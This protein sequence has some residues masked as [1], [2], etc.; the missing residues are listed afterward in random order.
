M[1]AAQHHRGPD[2]GGVWERV[3]PDGDRICLGSRRLAILD[4]S[5][6]GHMPMPNEDGSVDIYIQKTTPA[7]HESNWLPAAAGDFKLWLRT[8]R[9]GT[10]ILNGEYNVP[11]IP[12]AHASAVL[13]ACL[14]GFWYIAMS[15]GTPL[16]SVYWRRT[17]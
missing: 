4:L 15:D 9:P 13:R 6:A 11:P 8:Y 17:M 14:L 5:S 3:L 2:D 7:G 12:F 10:S 1:I 16:P